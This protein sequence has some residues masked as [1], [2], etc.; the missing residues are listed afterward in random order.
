MHMIPYYFITNYRNIKFFLR[1][2]IVIPLY[3]GSFQ[4]GKDFES[5]EIGNQPNGSE[6]VKNTWGNRRQ[7]NKWITIFVAV[8]VILITLGCF[9]C[10]A[11]WIKHKAEA[12]RK[13]KQKMLIQEL[14]GGNVIPS[15][16][17]D[18]VKKQNNDGQASQELQIFRF[19]SISA[20][21]SNFSI[22]NKLGE[23]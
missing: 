4:R 20:S 21:T 3:S 23:E 2:L 10:F 11:K 16:V 17:H 22:E 5:Y 12:D 8:V 1:R 13:K 19:E 6:G 9:L 7:S 18:K 15:T 14:G